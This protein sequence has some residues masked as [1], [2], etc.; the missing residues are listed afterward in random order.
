MRN[1]CGSGAGPSPRM[2]AAIEGRLKPSSKGTAM[3]LSFMCAAPL[4]SGRGRPPAPVVV[5]LSSH[6]RIG[7]RTDDRPHCELLVP[8]DGRLA[9]SAVGLAPD[10][11]D[12]R[13]DRNV[14]IDR[15]ER[16]RRPLV[17]AV[18]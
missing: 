8:L 15:G 14:R 10:H 1:G 12:F 13:S 16:K 18:A 2:T 7:R 4:A 6:D 3:V 5:L 11:A 9:A 17:L